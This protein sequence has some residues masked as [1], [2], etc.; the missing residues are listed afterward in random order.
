MPMWHDL[1]HD[2]RR[3]EFEVIFRDYP[4]SCFERGLELGAGDGFQSSLL[5]RYVSTLISSDINLS[6]LVLARKPGVQYLICDAGQPDRCFRRA[7]FDLVYS[8]HLLE[9]LEDP[10]RSLAGIRR[11][12]KEEGVCIHIMP[13]PFMKLTWMALFYPSKLFAAFEAIVRPHRREEVK[14]KLLGLQDHRA[15]GAWDNNPRRRRYSFLRRQVWPIPHGAYR[16]NLAE[17]VWYGKKRWVR[18]I[19]RQG[20]RV[21]RVLRLPVTSGTRFSWPW[22][23]RNL[24]RLGFAS[25]YAYV[26][27]K[28]R[29]PGAW[30]GSEPR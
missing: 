26:A 25:A 13:S 9:H 4:P 23:Q 28:K 19:E 10:E 6:R 15:G 20:F 16:S 8:S 5:K 1:L 11:I 24:E 18:R 17:L 3:R 14:G 30:A 7:S 2:L 12:L 21:L 27:A 29:L 22:L